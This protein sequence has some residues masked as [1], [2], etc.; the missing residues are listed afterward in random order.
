[1]LEQENELLQVDRERFLPLLINGQ[2]TL[3][4]D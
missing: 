4:S 1:L 3:K 2:L